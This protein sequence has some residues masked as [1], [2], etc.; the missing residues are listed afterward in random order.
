[1]RLWPQYRVSGLDST[2]EITSSPT[3]VVASADQVSSN[4]AFSKTWQIKES[5]AA[6]GFSMVELL[7]WTLPGRVFV[8]YTESASS[9]LLAEVVVSGNTKENVELIDMFG[10]LDA[11]GINL[12]APRITDDIAASAY[13]LTEIKLHQK[14][15]V[16]K[17][18]P[19]GTGEA[20]ILENVLYTKTKEDLAA[21]TSDAASVASK[22]SD[23]KLT[24]VPTQE[25]ARQ[26]TVTSSNK[27]T[28]INL[29]LSIP[30]FA[31]I[32][33][34]DPASASPGTIAVVA[35]YE[36]RDG[37]DKSTALSS[38]IPVD[39][40]EVLATHGN[41]SENLQLRVKPS[42]DAT[43]KK[44]KIA[45]S[46]QVIPSVQ[47]S[48]GN[49]VVDEITD[50][51]M[52]LDPDGL[53]MVFS[54]EGSV[55]I[56]DKE[57]ALYFDGAELLGFTGALQVD[58]GAISSTS[59]NFDASNNIEINLFAT[60]ISTMIPILASVSGNG[61]LCLS[62]SSAV[63][64]TQLNVT[65]GSQ[66]SYT[67][68]PDARKCVKRE[69]PARVPGKAI[70]V[71]E[72]ATSRSSLTPSTAPSS[73]SSTSG[74]GKP[75]KSAAVPLDSAGVAALTAAIVGIATIMTQ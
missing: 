5:A 1:M 15:T 50:A 26:W 55:F 38:K 24:E 63:K 67:E 49:S 34:L 44:L 32:D 3:V 43:G 19:A 52:D 25:T 48:V 73:T 64:V 17:F 58:V 21:L 30:G 40:V 56:S 29:D 33:T 22:T 12:Q 8:S 18:V 57:A 53:S 14:R 42:F 27:Y 4:Q 71:V 23:F 2:L 35:L 39:K 59:M 36:Q 28:K 62:S 20:V 75:A 41:G 60:T 31:Q 72:S 13:L 66:I 37:L 10:T 70:A 46:I 74:D 65:T 9:D 61:S 6:S 69:L 16:K 68:E 51:R 47:M 45:T 11:G 54:M 7:K